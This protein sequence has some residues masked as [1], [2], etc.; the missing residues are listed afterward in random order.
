MVNDAS[1]VIVCVDSVGS[2]LIRDLLGLFPMICT[3][4]KFSSK[5]HSCIFALFSSVVF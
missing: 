5:L 1:F 3:K 4:P 2:S